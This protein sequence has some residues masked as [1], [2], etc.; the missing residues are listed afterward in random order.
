MHHAHEVVLC[1][2]PPFLRY[3]SRCP[4]FVDGGKNCSLFVDHRYEQ[5]VY[6][7]D[8]MLLLIV[9]VMGCATHNAGNNLVD[10]LKESHRLQLHSSESISHFKHKVVTISVPSGR[11][12]R[13]DRTHITIC[14]L[15][16]T[17]DQLLALCNM[18][19]TYN[20]FVARYK[21]LHHDELWIGTRNGPSLHV[22]ENEAKIVLFGRDYFRTRIVA[23]IARQA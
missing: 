3:Q 10:L 17:I 21:R 13:A 8:R 7:T 16:D 22:I 14:V 9:H 15:T 12:R 5:I 23:F 4:R 20:S 1:R 6:H 11:R 19:K 18:S 2:A